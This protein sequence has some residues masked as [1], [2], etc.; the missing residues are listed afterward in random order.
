MAS[1]GLL[2]RGIAFV[3]DT[4]MGWSCYGLGKIGPEE[5]SLVADDLWSPVVGIQDNETCGNKNYNANHAFVN[6]SIFGKN[7]CRT[8]FA[9]IWHYEM[10]LSWLCV[11]QS[12][13]A[14]RGVIPVY[15]YLF[16]I[17]F[18][19]RSYSALPTNIKAVSY[20]TAAVVIRFASQYCFK[21]QI[22]TIFSWTNANKFYQNR[23]SYF[24]FGFK[25]LPS[26]VAT[27]FRAHVLYNE[28]ILV[29]ARIFRYGLS[30][31]FCSAF[32]STRTQ[33]F[34]LRKFRNENASIKLMRGINLLLYGCLPKKKKFVI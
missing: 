6:S 20:Y 27:Y 15:S 26:A 9:K 10:P 24:E 33:F 3:G 31:Q 19:F 28:W 18:Q 30:P 29:I 34:W 17:Q 8:N 23:F 7:T 22:G 1:G 21:T 11:A 25:N 14:C 13:G 16:Q 12:T 2:V 5:F 4:A 32:L